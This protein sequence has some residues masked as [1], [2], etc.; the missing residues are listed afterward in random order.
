MS[1]AGAAA[2]TT[3]AP[4]GA[5]AETKFFILLG[6]FAGAWGL[7][8]SITPLLVPLDLGWAGLGLLSF[9]FGAFLHAITY[10][11][12]ETVI[13]VWGVAR[14]RVM[15]F[16]AIGIYVVAVATLSLGA[17]LPAP[18]DATAHDA[19]TTLYSSVWRLVIASLCATVTAQLLDIAVFRRV[20][21]LTGQRALWLRNLLAVLTSQVADTTIFYTVA[22]Y[23][24][25]PDDVLP[26]L[27][28]GT[29]LVKACFALAGIPV[30]YALVRWITGQWT[31]SGDLGVVRSAPTP[32]SR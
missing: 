26:K 30:V 1:A 12:L 24:I 11:C 29:I 5:A 13:E 17:A 28:L 6:A 14:A 21:A 16:V 10:P 32:G 9:S 15:V 25:V 23:G 7:L 27:V 8:P 22:F 2:P 3:V 20:K 31:A 4:Y 19:F 18:Q